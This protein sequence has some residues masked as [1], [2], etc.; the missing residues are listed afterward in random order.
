M[1]A[2]ENHDATNKGKAEVQTDDGITHLLQNSN[3]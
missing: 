2:N 3:L 1:N